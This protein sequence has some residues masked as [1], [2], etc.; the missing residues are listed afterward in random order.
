MR[1]DRQWGAVIAGLEDNCW[2][3]DKEQAAAAFK[4][5]LSTLA[6]A[7]T[8]LL[9]ASVVRRLLA[10]FSPLV[11]WLTCIIL[12]AFRFAVVHAHFRW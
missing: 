1:D 8:R 2:L 7:G 3:A 6:R 5:E 11:G 10:C 12:Q 4:R 9:P